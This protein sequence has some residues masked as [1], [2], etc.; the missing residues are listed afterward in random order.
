MMKEQITRQMFSRRAR[1]AAAMSFI[2]GL[3]SIVLNIWPALLVLPLQSWLGE[4]FPLFLPL[5]VGA[6]A[7]GLGVLGLVWAPRVSWIA[8]VGL[9]FGAIGMALGSLLAVVTVTMLLQYEASRNSPL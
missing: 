3:I 1:C 6:S 4:Y 7:S 8:I 9:V 2:L 5:A